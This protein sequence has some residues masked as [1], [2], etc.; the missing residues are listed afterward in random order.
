[1]LQVRS[2]ISTLEPNVLWNCFADLNAVPR[3]SKREARV[4]AFARAFAEQHGLTS[5][6]DSAGNV[7][8]KK[9]ATPD[10]QDRPAVIPGWSPTAESPILEKMK[11]IYRELFGHDV[12]VSACHAGLE[13][14]VIAM[15]YPDLDMISFGPNIHEAHSEKECCSISSTQKFWKLLTTTLAAM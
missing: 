12:K 1:M 10:R 11:P 14:G 6:L 2:D 15:A 8:L 5:M 4:V 13:C 7:I 9:P 3:P